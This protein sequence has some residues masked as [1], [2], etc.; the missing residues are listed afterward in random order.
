MVY[1]GNIWGD[2]RIHEVDMKADATAGVVSQELG[3]ATASIQ[4]F[5]ERLN[6]LILVCKA[7]F[8][9]LHERAGVTEQELAEKI[10]EIDLRDGKKD[11]VLTPQQKKC[12]DCGAGVCAKFRRC[13]FCG[14]E[15]KEGDVFT[16]I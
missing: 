2:L 5:E 11:G 14:Y 4:Q 13:L 15:D 10:V 12:P 1:G 7:S 8:E 3:N 9:L 6:K 16:T